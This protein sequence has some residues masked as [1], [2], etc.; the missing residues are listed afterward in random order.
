MYSDIAGFMIEQAGWLTLTSCP[1]IL[2]V[3]RWIFVWSEGHSGC[4]S[5]NREVCYT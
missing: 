2:E 1:Q 3:E 4:S 5:R